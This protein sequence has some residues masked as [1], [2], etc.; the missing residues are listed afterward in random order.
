[1]GVHITFGILDREDPSDPTSQPLIR[2]PA[3]RDP[4]PAG[5]SPSSVLP[6]RPTRSL[7]A[8]AW[9]TWR[10]RRRVRAIL[11]HCHVP[12]EVTTCCCA[13]LDD[14]LLILLADLH[15]HDRRWAW[16][17]WCAPH[18]DRA[19]WLLAWAQRARAT[20]GAQARISFS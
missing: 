15:A 16:L 9:S 13:P 8:R 20:F 18:T 1:M 6:D 19:H 12:A 3:W 2:W 11:A 4:A 7:S 5:A 10:E 14:Q 17:P